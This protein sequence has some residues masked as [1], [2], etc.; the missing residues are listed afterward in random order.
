[1][2]A[3][4][5]RHVAPTLVYASRGGTGCPTPPCDWEWLL[6]RLGLAVLAGPG[7]VAQLAGDRDGHALF[8][9]VAAFSAS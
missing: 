5:D 9:M 6:R 7:V 2:P 8:R 3:G 4:N 1:M